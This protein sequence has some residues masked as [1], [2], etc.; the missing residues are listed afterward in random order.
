MV[1]DMDAD[2]GKLGYRDLVVQAEFFGQ[3][4]DPDSTHSDALPIL[5]IISR[6]R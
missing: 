4:H 6:G 2:L 1:F 3:L 5:T